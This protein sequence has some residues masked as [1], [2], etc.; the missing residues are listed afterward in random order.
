[1]SPM[2]PFAQ[3]RSSGDEVLFTVR[4]EDGRSASIYVKRATAAHGNNVVMDIALEQQNKGALP[5]GTIVSVER[6]R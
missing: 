4:Y 6:V 1:M 5:A 2:R 3:R